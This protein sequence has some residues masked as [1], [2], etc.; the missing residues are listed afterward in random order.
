[1]S[2]ARSVKFT[3]SDGEE[4]LDVAE[5]K[6]VL[7]EMLDCDSEEEYNIMCKQGLVISFDIFTRNT[8][9]SINN[10]L[11][12]DLIENAVYSTENITSIRSI[13]CESSATGTIVF[14]VRGEQ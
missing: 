9:I 12:N 7:M 5:I 14:R 6:E 4:L 8:R 2:Y 1:M 11:W 10:G 13:K 3:A